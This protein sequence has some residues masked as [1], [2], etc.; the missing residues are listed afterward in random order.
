MRARL[1]RRLAS[2]DERFT[3]NLICVVGLINFIVRMHRIDQLQ[4]TWS[5]CN[6]LFTNLELKLKLQLLG[7]GHLHVSHVINELCKPDIVFMNGFSFDW[8][9]RVQNSSYFEMPRSSFVTQCFQN[10]LHMCPNVLWPSVKWLMSVVDVI[11]AWAQ[12]T[13]GYDGYWT[14]M[15]FSP[16]ARIEAIS[17]KTVITPMETKMALT[18]DEEADEEDVHFYKSGLV[19]HRSSFDPEAFSDSEYAR[20][21][22]DRKS[23]TGGCQF[24]RS[25]LISWQCKKKNLSGYLLQKKMNMNNVYHS[26]TMLIELDTTL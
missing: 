19:S 17:V 8:L 7:M 12:V 6:M 3:M 5:T 13:A 2:S 10:H 1:H 18:K 24:L 11:L 4:R 26:K 22:L 23:I 14:M 16:V 21:N 9:R 15:S 25:R 20:A